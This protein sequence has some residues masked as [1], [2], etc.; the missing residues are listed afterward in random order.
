VLR[1]LIDAL[2]PSNNPVLSPAALKAAIDTGGGS[3]LAGLRHFAADMARPL[4]IPSMVEP[5][6]FKVGLDLAVTPGAVVARTEG[7]R[8][9]VAWLLVLPGCAVTASA[10]RP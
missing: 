1:N 8:S 7:R 9:A 4:R 10:L 2:A 6:A 3:A 5:D